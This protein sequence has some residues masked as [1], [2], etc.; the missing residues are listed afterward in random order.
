MEVEPPPDC[1]AKG[2][3][4]NSGECHEFTRARLRVWHLLVDI[5]VVTASVLTDVTHPERRLCWASSR[6]PP[7]AEHASSSARTRLGLCRW[8]HSL[9]VAGDFCLSHRIGD[10]ICHPGWLG[11]NGLRV[12]IF[13]RRNHSHLHLLRKDGPLPQRGMTPCKANE[14]SF[15]TLGVFSAYN[16]LFFTWKQGSKL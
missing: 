16:S 15:K 6:R 7:G 12:T 13:C 2:G 11:T 4:S 14:K 3:A 8:P 9:P 5:S 1:R 10:F